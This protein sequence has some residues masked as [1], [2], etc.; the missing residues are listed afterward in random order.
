[1]A[2]EVRVNACDCCH[3]SLE[4]CPDCGVRLA[5]HH[6]TR[7]VFCKACNIKAS[8]VE[9]RKTPMEVMGIDGHS[10]SPVYECPE[11][12]DKCCPAD[13]KL[14]EVYVK[15]EKPLNIGAWIDQGT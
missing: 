2:F 11:C 8:Q 6:P 3:Q 15:I 13:G 7:E 5:H 4:V 1:M 12:G 9:Y 10:L 14:E